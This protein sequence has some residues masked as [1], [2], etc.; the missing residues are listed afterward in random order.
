MEVTQNK[1]TV[2]Q[3]KADARTSQKN[4]VMEP[5]ERPE[6]VSRSG[7]DVV[8]DVY[9]ATLALSCLPDVIYQ[10]V[11]NFALDHLS[12][13]DKQRIH[14]TIDY[15]SLNSVLVLVAETIERTMES[16]EKIAAQEERGEAV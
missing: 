12:M 7:L 14:L 10:T 16:L 9:S 5:K 1:K 2:T 13:T 8:Q 4:K 15:L 6:K 3:K 11:D